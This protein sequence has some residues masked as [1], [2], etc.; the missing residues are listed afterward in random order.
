MTRPSIILLPALLAALPL[1][2]CISF[3]AAP[4]PSLLT[5]TPA[6]SLPIGETTSSATAPTIAIS[7]PSFP[8][9]LATTRVPV[10][11]SETSIAYVK[12]AQWSEPPARLFARLLADTIAAKTGRVV[13][14]GAQALGDQGARLSGELRNFGADEASGDAIVSYEAV[15]KRGDGDGFEKRRFEARE[16]TGAISATSVGPALNRAAN[17]VAADV[18]AWIGR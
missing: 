1:S 14:G 12:D 9:A 5:L 10:K 15:L 6:V 17:R 16:P 2:A 11:T 8:Q 18:A 4:P 3:G 13:L 7:V